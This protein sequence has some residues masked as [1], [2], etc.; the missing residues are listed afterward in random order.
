MQRDQKEQSDYISKWISQ[1]LESAELVA[2][3]PQNV[4]DFS[5]PLML[6]IVYNSP[7]FSPYPALWESSL[8]RLPVVKERY[9]PIRI[10][11]ETKF[12]YSLSVTSQKGKIS[13]D[14]GNEKPRNVFVEMKILDGGKKCSSNTCNLNLEWRTDA[15]FADPS[16]Y[17][18]VRQEWEAAL[19]LAKP[20]IK[21]E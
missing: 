20:K 5:K 3:M 18:S 8:M 14:V 17:E 11:H 15:V 16:E 19:R 1:S 21:V 2:F 4:E 9:H 6:T 7:Q 13:L 10:P 12:H